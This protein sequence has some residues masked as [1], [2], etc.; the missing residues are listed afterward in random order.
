MGILHGGSKKRYRFG[1]PHRNVAIHSFVRRVLSGLGVPNPNKNGSNRTSTTN[2]RTCTFSGNKDEIKSQIPARESDP[3]QC[4]K[5]EKKDFSGSKLLKIVLE[6]G[7]V[8]MPQE[9]S[10]SDCRLE[11]R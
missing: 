7:K 8:P 9:V 6:S 5:S 11:C 4:S 3:M 2:R 10:T 1:N